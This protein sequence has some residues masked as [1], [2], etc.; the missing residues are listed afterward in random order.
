M[1]DYIR[2]KTAQAKTHVLDNQNQTSTKPKL[3]C[4]EDRRIH[5]IVGQHQHQVV[6]RKHALSTIIAE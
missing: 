3:S 2:E 4:H 1:N 5:D 6:R